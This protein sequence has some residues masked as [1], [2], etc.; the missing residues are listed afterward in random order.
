MHSGGIRQNAAVNNGLVHNLGQSKQ[1]LEA[2][3]HR[4]S[5]RHLG[6]LRHHNDSAAT[7]PLWKS[8]VSRIPKGIQAGRTNLPTIIQKNATQRAEVPFM[9]LDNQIS[10]PG[11]HGMKR[12]RMRC[13]AASEIKG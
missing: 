2:F 5:L 7:L 13:M 1:Y 9:Y 3:D 11:C 6:L 8:L 4:I 10:L 12:V